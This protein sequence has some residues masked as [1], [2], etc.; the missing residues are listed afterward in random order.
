MAAERFPDSDALTKEI[1]D[2]WIHECSKH[3]QN[4]L[5]GRITPVRQFAK[6]LVGTGVSAY[7]IP[8]KIPS[9]QIFSDTDY[10]LT[11]AE[12]FYPELQKRM[13]PVNLR[14]LPEVPHE[15]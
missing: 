15:D 14:I 4:T 8:G 5:L 7:I 2:E 1:C 13:I 12:P 10:Y 6:Y 11:F 9:R 3:H